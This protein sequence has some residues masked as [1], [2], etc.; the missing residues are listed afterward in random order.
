MSHKLE[1]SFSA[2]LGLML[3]AWLFGLCIGLLEALSQ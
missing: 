1:I 3:L 2:L